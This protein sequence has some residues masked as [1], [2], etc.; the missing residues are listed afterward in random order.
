MDKVIGNKT[1]L[2]VIVNFEQLGLL[3][4]YRPFHTQ[5]GKFGMFWIQLLWE[6]VGL[7]YRRK[8]IQGLLGGA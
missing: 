4:I 3:D 6:D 1:I 8:N 5:I 7:N 2:I